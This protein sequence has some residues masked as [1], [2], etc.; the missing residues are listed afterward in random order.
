MEAPSG[1]DRKRL[2]PDAPNGRASHAADGLRQPHLPST[3]GSGFS[4]GMQGKSK[5]CLKFFS[6]CGCPYGEGC[7]FSHYIQGGISALAT[8]GLGVAGFVKPFSSLGSSGLAAPP[9]SASDAGA[10]LG[11]YKTRLCNR[12]GTSEGC[13]FGEKCHFAHG[14]KELR[15]ANGSGGSTQGEGGSFAFNVS[16]AP[17]ASETNRVYPGL[18]DFT[19]SNSHGTG[20]GFSREPSPPGIAAS[21]GSSSTNKI[22]INATMAGAIIGK[23]GMHA[24]EISRL[25]GA[26]LAIRDHE[27]NPNLRNIELEGTFDQIKIANQIVRDVLMHKDPLPPKPAGFT[28]HNYKTRMCENYSQ[29]TCTFGERCHFAH[30]DAELR[31]PSFPA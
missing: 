11:G 31:K 19:S 14:E 30:G 25:T 10:N 6:T 15:K 23:G 9:I 24:K 26:K 22:S 18:R 20:V 13:R 3:N 2:R 4:A 27:N 12:F 29:G 7:H 21:F 28:P 8:C 16:V 5:P 1:P 17:L